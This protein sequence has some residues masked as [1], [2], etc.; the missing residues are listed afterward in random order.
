MKVNAIPDR[1]GVLV[2]GPPD[3]TNPDNPRNLQGGFRFFR[4]N[5]AGN[6]RFK[7]NVGTGA[8][9]SWF[10]GGEAADVVP[11]TDEWHHF[12]ISMSADQATV[13]I[14]G[15]VVSQGTLPGPVDWTGTDIL[16]I[17]SG[18]PRFTGWNHLADRSFMD[19][20]R[21]FNRGLTEEEVNEIFTNEGGT[22]GTGY[23]PKFDGEQ[24]YVG[25]DQ[26]DFLE[27][28]SG[29]ELTV[30]G[31]PTLSEDGRGD[32]G[33]YEGAEGA[34]L[35]YPASGLLTNE[36]S[37]S[38]W[39]KIDADPNRAGILV[40]GPPD[41]DNPDNPNRR[42]S[43]FRFFREAAGEEE[44]RF[45]LNVGTGEGQSWFDGGEAADL[46]VDSEEWHHLAF[47]IAAD[48]AAVYI[49]GQEVA[50]GEFPGI[51]W[52]DCNL[53]SI[54]SGAPNFVGWN[55]RSDR[56]MLDDLRL[57]DKALTAEEVTALYNE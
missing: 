48:R 50:S 31:S 32:G 36:F 40:I 16:S 10:D 20:L 55:H 11:G 47:S 22:A 45:K 46:P 23:T 19:E 8:G 54:M 30:V 14:D 7:L 27:M 39:M 2:I 41:P 38:M 17:M 9:D 37:A 29:T 43:G 5:A 35:T 51:D 21:I 33:A 56:G 6:Q 44:Q 34:Y 53:L 57:F 13:M 25:F 18:A 52:T 24:F 4:E 49:D 26:E 3:P 1:A 28:I 12:A 42:T 15:V